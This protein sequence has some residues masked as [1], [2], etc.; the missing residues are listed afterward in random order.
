[1]ANGFDFGLPAGLAYRHNFQQDIQNRARLHQMKRQKRIDQ[2]NDA[3]LW[4]K[5]L[6]TI[7]VQNP[8]DAAG[9]EGF[10]DGHF[11]KMGKWI[12]EHPNF[13]TQPEEYVYWTKNFVKPIKDNEWVK[14]DLA[15]Q[16]QKKMASAYAA[17]KGADDV[18]SIE[19]NEQIGNYS[20]YGN[21]KGELDARQF[22]V[23]EFMFVAPSEKV[24]VV[25]ELQQVGN[26]MKE[27]Q[28]NFDSKLG[29]Y[30]GKVDNKTLE[31]SAMSAYT[32][33]RLKSAIDEQYEFYKA[34]N[35]TKSNS[36]LE[37]ASEVISSGSPT[38]FKPLSAGSKSKTSWYDNLLASG[39]S[40]WRHDIMNKSSATGIPQEALKKALGEL[41]EVYMFSD[42]STEKKGEALFLG[43]QD[44]KWTG[45]M[46]TILNPR[47]AHLD[48]KGNIIPGTEKTS[49]YLEVQVEVPW[50]EAVSMD[51]GKYWDWNNEVGTGDIEDNWKKYAHRTKNANG[52]WVANIIGYVPIDPTR[53]STRLAFD[54]SV[55]PSKLMQPAMADADKMQMLMNNFDPEE[56]ENIMKTH[57]ILPTDVDATS[58]LWNIVT[59]GR[60]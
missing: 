31:A 48:N 53:E 41:G 9:L 35:L 25:K 8:Y 32:D 52:E 18:H 55:Q 36:A 17:S 20:K 49:K 42:P 45:K 47:S 34:N 11:K 44:V 5:E 29:G 21:Y 24:N 1:M 54:Q 51:V 15:F 46:Q 23:N 22:G 30:V 58:R 26:R 14:R 60:Q 59:A 6:D 38:E 43:K 56:I 27:L 10:L 50:D 19:M 16:Q 13:R 3:R 4:A 28:Y 37:F 7:S 57:N 12:Q 33:P 40:P 2:E 39:Q